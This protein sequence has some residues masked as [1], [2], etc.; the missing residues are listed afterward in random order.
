MRKS[1]G[2]DNNYYQNNGIKGDTMKLCLTGKALDRQV[3]KAHLRYARGKITIEEVKKI[4]R[5]AL[6]HVTYCKKC[7]VD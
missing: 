2:F 7:R 3:I 5:R 6:V 1:L 4:E